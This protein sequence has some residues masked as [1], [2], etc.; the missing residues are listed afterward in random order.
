MGTLCCLKNPTF[1]TLTTK[2][3][4]AVTF[5]GSD[6]ILHQMAEAL[7]DYSKK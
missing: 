4:M 5:L 3:A 7:Q 2:L 1:I 6:L